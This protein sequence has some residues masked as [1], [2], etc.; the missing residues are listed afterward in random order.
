ML[1]GFLICTLLS[2]SL[3]GCGGFVI[4]V[5]PQNAATQFPTTTPNIILPTPATLAPPSTVTFPPTPFTM[6]ST[7]TPTLP[8]PTS[9]FTP[10]LE[11]TLTEIPITPSLTAMATDTATAIGTV[12]TPLVSITVTILGCNTSIDITHGMGEVTNAYITVSNIGTTELNN[13][14]ATLNALDEGRPH[15]DKTK[16]VPTLPIS[17]QVTQKLTVDTTFHQVT[18]IQ[19]EVNDNHGLLQRVAQDA[20]TNI[21]IFVPDGSDLGVVKPIPNP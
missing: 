5:S 20:C 6:T 9:T 8:G 19:I 1:R 18:P 11:P 12:P 3:T 13:V 10:F 7:I 14:C 16:C 2:L 21:G 15:P 17:Y 4:V